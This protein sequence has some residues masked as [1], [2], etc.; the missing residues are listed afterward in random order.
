MGGTGWGCFGSRDNTRE[1]CEVLTADMVGANSWKL[2]APRVLPLAPFAAGLPLPFAAP[3]SA[4]GL[5]HDVV[6]DALGL[7]RH[8]R[9]QR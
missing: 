6:L 9:L 8:E 1:N 7:L 5:L 2:T 3:E 4:L